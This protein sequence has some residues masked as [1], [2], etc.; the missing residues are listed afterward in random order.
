MKPWEQKSHYPLLI[1]VS[2]VLVAPPGR[3]TKFPWLVFS[4]VLLRFIQYFSVIVLHHFLHGAVSN[5]TSAE[6]KRASPTKRQQRLDFFFWRKRGAIRA[7][8]SL[9]ASDP[10]QCRPSGSTR[11][12]QDKE[13][14]IWKWYE[15]EVGN[16]RQELCNNLE[17]LFTPFNLFKIDSWATLFGRL[18]SPWKVS[19]CL[20]SMVP[21]RAVKY[22]W[23]IKMN[24]FT[25]AGIFETHKIKLPFRK[26]SCC[27]SLQWR[28][29]DSSWSAAFGGRIWRKTSR[30]SS[31]SPAA[32]ICCSIAATLGCWASPRR[33]RARN[34]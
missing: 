8:K 17:E 27:S 13:R 15:I 1:R 30:V 10:D 34:K 3:S 16:W 28:R 29:H 22:N 21:C 11:R 2:A 4:L 24:N 9:S 32:G 5:A 12:R 26:C 14:E 7:K 33:P 19:G 18:A 20:A 23:K 31:V 25:S 6:R